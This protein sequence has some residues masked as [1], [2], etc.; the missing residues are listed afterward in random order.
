MLIL[1]TNICGTPGIPNSCSVPLSQVQ[2]INVTITIF[3]LIHVDSVE[4][5]WLDIF[6]ASELALCVFS[7]TGYF[8]ISIQRNKLRTQLEHRESHTQV[9]L[10]MMVHNKLFIQ[11]SLVN[12]YAVLWPRDIGIRLQNSSIPG[13]RCTCRLFGSR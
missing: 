4:G 10:S 11:L 9:L 12:Q 1:G 8:P 6:G 2:M 3:L 13:V 7:T 5:R